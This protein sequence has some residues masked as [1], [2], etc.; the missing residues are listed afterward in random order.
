MTIISYRLQ[1][2]I[3]SIYLWVDRTHICIETSCFIVI[4]QLTVH[5]AMISIVIRKLVNA[6]HS[7]ESYLLLSLHALLSNRSTSRFHFPDIRG[8]P[9]FDYS[10]LL[11]CICVSIREYL[12]AGCW[13]VDRR[14]SWN[15]SIQRVGII[16]VAYKTCLIRSTY[17]RS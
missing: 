3:K 4:E 17:R 2:L 5:V 10:T 9:F 6:W 11:F 14:S 15:A 8:R 7:T 1:L 12:E 16:R 13:R